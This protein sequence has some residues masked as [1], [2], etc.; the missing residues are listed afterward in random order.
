MHKGH[1]ATFIEQL[2]LLVI[3]LHKTDKTSAWDMIFEVLSSI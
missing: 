2:D 3:L 1:K